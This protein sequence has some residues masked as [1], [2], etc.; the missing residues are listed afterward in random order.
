MII[1]DIFI[2]IIPPQQSSQTQQCY[3]RRTSH[4]LPP[5]ALRERR[6]LSPLHEKTTQVTINLLT[7]KKS[8]SPVTRQI[9]TGT[10]KSKY[11][12]SSTDPKLINTMAG[13]RR[14]AQPMHMHGRSRRKAGKSLISGHIF[15]SVGLAF[16]EVQLI[17]TCDASMPNGFSP[18]GSCV[19][20]RDSAVS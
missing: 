16:V 17:C 19:F 3:S 20:P 1:I 18:C 8:N 9:N 12:T 5:W 4:T 11:M 10:L 7:K 15:S 2:I 13:I 6:Q 14:R